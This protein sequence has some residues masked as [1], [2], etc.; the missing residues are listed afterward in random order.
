[1]RGVRSRG[2]D[3]LF[4]DLGQ[5]LRVATR[6]C[7]VDAD[8][9]FQHRMASVGRIT[10][11]G[12]DRALAAGEGLGADARAF[13]IAPPQGRREALQAG[14]G[15]GVKA[16]SLDGAAAECP[17]GAG[18][19]EGGCGRRAEAQ[20]RGTGIGRQPIGLAGWAGQDKRFT[21]RC[22]LA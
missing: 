19:L 18:L 20:N 11:Q 1:M 16:R 17:D 7:G 8:E 9:A 15:C 3:L 10:D 14:Q 5:Q 6:G 12:Q 21:R 22:G 13:G 2:L 4:R